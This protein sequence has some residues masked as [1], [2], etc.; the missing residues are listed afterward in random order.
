[1]LFYRLSYT[2]QQ[3]YKGHLLAGLPHHQQQESKIFS[4]FVNLYAMYG[5]A[6]SDA[7]PFRISQLFTTPAQYNLAIGYLLLEFRRKIRI[8]I[9]RSTQHAPSR[10]AGI[11]WV[12]A[13]IHIALLA[14][15]KKTQMLHPP[16][17]IKDQGLKYCTLQVLPSEAVCAYFAQTASASI[18]PSSET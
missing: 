4:I 15:R 16:I 17:E 6:T 9:K 7:L 5:L 10:S 14:C 18:S 2:D 8:T 12:F 11:F 13:S 3:G 1:M